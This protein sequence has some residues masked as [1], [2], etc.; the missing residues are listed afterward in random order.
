MTCSP[1]L[2]AVF[3]AV[4][5]AWAERGL[6][7]LMSAINKHKANILFR[8]IAITSATVTVAVVIAPIAAIAAILVIFLF[9]VFIWFLFF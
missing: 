3:S 7:R 4:H 2:K 1:D 8:L 5:C 6:P 9:L